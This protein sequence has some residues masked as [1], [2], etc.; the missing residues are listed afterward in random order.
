MSPG[1]TETEA[2][3]I[4]PVEVG[5]KSTPDVENVGNGSTQNESVNL[6]EVDESFPIEENAE[7]WK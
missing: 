7:T 4:N 3:P 2:L 6:G 1:S 5:E